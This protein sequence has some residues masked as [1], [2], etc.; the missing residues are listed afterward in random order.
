MPVLLTILGISALIFIHEFGHYICARLAGVKVHVF[1]LGFGTRLWGFQRGGTDYRISM[2][3]IGGYV[4]VA[5]EDPTSDRLLLRPDDLHSKGFL[6]RTLFYS[7]GVVMNVLFALVVFPIVFKNGVEFDAPV[8]GNVAKG[9][10]SWE[11]G[12]QSGDRVLTVAGKEMYS[13]NNM[14]VEV[15]LASSTRGVDLEFRRG[16]EVRTCTLQPRYSERR[17]LRDMGAEHSFKPGPYELEVEPGSAAHAAGMRDGD[18]LVSFAGTRVGTADEYTDAV[19]RWHSA[20]TPAST[21]HP[22]KVTVRVRRGSPGTELDFTFEAPPDRDGARMVGV[23]H[24]GRRVAG[25]RQGV[26][27]L[28]RLGLRHD[29]VILFVNEQ[30]FRGGAIDLGTAPGEVGL[31]VRRHGEQSQLRAA[32]PVDRRPAVA[33][34]IALGP[35]DGEIFVRPLPGSPAAE[36]GITVGAEIKRVGGKPITTWAEFADSVKRTGDQPLEFDLLTSE[37]LQSVKVTPRRSP[38]LGFGPRIPALRDLYQVEGLGNTIEAGWVASMDL[39]K[40]VYVTLKRLFTGEVSTKNLGG[41]ITIS[42]VSYAT[43]QEGMARLFYF[44]ALLSINL[45]V[46]NVLPIPV[47]DGGHL[48]FLLIERVKGSPVSTRVHNYSQILGLVFV[49]ALMVYVTYNDIL[50]LL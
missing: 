23:Y 8:I 13:F 10:P 38:Y 30:P 4:Q 7:G 12:L 5:G 25:L 49:L 18:I 37:G 34:A 48:M 27:E 28:T 50:K 6:A 19:D 22:P 44:L 11:A 32:I 24:V 47:L 2:L 16:D 35:V 36:A 14:V 39:I 9:G 42:R 21:E 15:A 29:D 46:I 43:A 1:S 3:P 45:A 33:D 40:Q 41:I 26:P 17:G 20:L 31:V